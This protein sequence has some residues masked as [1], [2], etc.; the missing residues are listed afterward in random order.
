[1]AYG[2]FQYLMANEMFQCLVALGRKRK[3]ILV[4]YFHFLA[5]ILFKL[6]VFI[7]FKV[8]LYHGYR[9]LCYSFPSYKL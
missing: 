9:S 8:L 3:N 5:Q 4:T 2:R 6:F 1:M 7:Y